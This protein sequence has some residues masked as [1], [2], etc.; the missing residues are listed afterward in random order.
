M[1]GDHVTKTLVQ[2]V[3]DLGEH[4]RETC[5]GGLEQL[6]LRSQGSVQTRFHG[7]DSTLRCPSAS[8]EPA[9][10]LRLINSCA[11]L[12]A[13]ITARRSPVLLVCL[14]I[15]PIFQSRKAATASRS[16]FSA[17]VQAT[18]NSLPCSLMS[19]VLRRSFV[20]QP[21][22]HRFEPLARRRHPLGERLL[23]L[24][25]AGDAFAQGMI[26]LAQLADRTRRPARSW[27]RGKRYRCPS[28]ASFFEKSC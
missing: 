26:L 20:G 7:S 13:V 1:V 3:Y 11:R 17:G 4:R 23:F 22:H 6:F 24:F 21:F 27:L 10:S 9:G 15:S 28:A 2:G 18:R 8:I 25:Q 5:G 16:S 19:R 12:S 14:A